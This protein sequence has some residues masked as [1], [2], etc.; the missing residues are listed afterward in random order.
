MVD[1]KS[2]SSWF[3][4][5]KGLGTF[6]DYVTISRNTITIS[7]HLFAKAPKGYMRAKIGYDT[8][9][10]SL[11]IKPTGMDDPDGYK[12]ITRGNK[13]GKLTVFLNV[14][15]FINSYHLKFNLHKRKALRYDADWDTS[16]EWIVVKDV[17]R[18]R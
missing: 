16:N 12:L 6:G 5:N 2:F 3:T 9:T 10:G 4:P 17:Q 18:D 15:S 11:Y 13:E 14:L 1:K 7:A 8:D